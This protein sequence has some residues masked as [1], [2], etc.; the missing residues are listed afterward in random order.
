MACSFSVNCSRRKSLDRYVGD[1]NVDAPWKGNYKEAGI[2]IPVSFQERP[3]NYFVAL[4]LDSASAIAGGREIWGW[5]KKE[6]EISYSEDH[7]I[8]KEERSAR[9]TATDLGNYNLG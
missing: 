1:L 3:G 2:G 5:P 6:V 8:G 7:S 9:R 4:Y